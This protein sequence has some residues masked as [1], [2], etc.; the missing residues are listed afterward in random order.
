MPGLLIFVGQIIR[1][2]IGSSYV[3]NY[4]ISFDWRALVLVVYVT[5]LSRTSWQP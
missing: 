4:Y 2:L 3:N 5:L 1:K